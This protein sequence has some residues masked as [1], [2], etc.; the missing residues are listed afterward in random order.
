MVHVQYIKHHQI[1]SNF[2]FFSDA[3]TSN[4]LHPIVS[5][6]YIV[7]TNSPYKMILT[8]GDKG[9]GMHKRITYWELHIG[10]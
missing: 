6:Q 10:Y 1:P 4:S 3:I 8:L 7:S 2:T 9:K 5:S